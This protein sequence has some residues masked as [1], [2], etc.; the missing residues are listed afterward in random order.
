[1]KFFLH[2]VII[3]AIL[4]TFSPGRLTGAG[5]AG[6]AARM[7]QSVVLRRLGRVPGDV[8]FYCRS[9]VTGAELSVRADEP[10]LAASVI[11]LPVY[12]AIEKLA[13]EGRASL[14]E[15]LV[16]READKLPGCGALS[17]FA[18]EPEAD[19]AT[20][21]RLMIQLSDNTAANLLIRRFGI[22][23]L[24][25]EFSRMGLIGTR[26]FRLLYDEAAAKAGLENRFVPRELGSLL[27]RVYRR[28]FVSEAVSRRIGE[29][30]MG[31]QIRH[32]IPGYLPEGIEVA[33]KTGEDE[34]IVNDVGIVYAKEPFVIAFA[35]NHSDV[36]EAERAIREISL[37]FIDLPL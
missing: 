6:A 27:E 16:C 7:D 26:L 2:P 29:T 36:P 19:V 18:G 12:A 30:L 14:S 9:L 32:K 13:A 17:L 1:M 34:G 20:L 15:A 21:C 8:G 31:Q 4:C 23:T 35:A 11:K 28:T 24:N 33:N 3:Y 5:M 37:G 25:E 10:F 22:G